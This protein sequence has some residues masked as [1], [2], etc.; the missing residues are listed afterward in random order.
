MYKC[1]CHKELTN[2]LKDYRKGGLALI[3]QGI[4]DTLCSLDPDLIPCET[5]DQLEVFFQYLD[6]HIIENRRQLA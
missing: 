1:L 2:P 6:Q 5:L 4:S 3:E